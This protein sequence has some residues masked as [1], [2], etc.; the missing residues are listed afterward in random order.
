MKRSD[1]AILKA[2]EANKENMEKMAEARNKEFMENMEKHFGTEKDKALA[3]AETMLRQFVPKGMEDYVKSL[4]DSSMLVLSAVLNNVHK[5]GRVED[6]ILKDVD[7]VPDETP[8][9]LRETAK[10][11]MMSTE[12][13]DQFHPNHD[14]TK[15]RV[16]E[17]YQKIAGA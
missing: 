10:K 1:E 7:N 6:K 3:V 14:A 5:S 15:K 11:L 9:S 16:R 2:Y 4:D 17:L 8:E 12:F 13:R